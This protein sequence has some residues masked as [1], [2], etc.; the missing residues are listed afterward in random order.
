MIITNSPDNIIAG[1]CVSKLKQVQ[2]S[3]YML[4]SAGIFKTS[5]ICSDEKEVSTKKVY[6]TGCTKE[7]G[8]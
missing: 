4:R 8:S 1:R 2:S 5:K 6:I 7:M 3:T